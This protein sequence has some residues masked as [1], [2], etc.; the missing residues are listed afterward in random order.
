MSETLQRFS[1]VIGN[2]KWKRQKGQV[3]GLGYGDKWGGIENS[4]RAQLTGK[5]G[6]V[7]QDGSFLHSCYRH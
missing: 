6:D 2:V 7:V 3:A 5:N 4:P 1:V